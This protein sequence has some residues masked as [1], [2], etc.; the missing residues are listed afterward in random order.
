MMLRWQVTDQ[1]DRDLYGEIRELIRAHKVAVSPPGVFNAAGGMIDERTL[2]VFARDD[3][4]KLVGALLGATYWGVLSIGSLWVEEAARNQGHARTLLQHAIAEARTRGCTLIYGNT[5]ETQGA[6]TLYD[7]LGAQLVWR[8][9]YPKIGQ[10][11]LWYRVDLNE[12]D[13]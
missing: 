5:W 9:E 13:L 8:Q 6:Y 7:K 3:E 4:G 11:L 12:I 10:T 1:E 2:N